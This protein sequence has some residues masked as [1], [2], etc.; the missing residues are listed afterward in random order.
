MTIQYTLWD[1]FKMLDNYNS[2]QILNMAKMISYLFIQKALP[3]SILKV[4]I[5]TQIVF[6]YLHLYL[7]IFFFR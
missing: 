5:N 2:K 6:L 4:N 3:L 1:K 7:N